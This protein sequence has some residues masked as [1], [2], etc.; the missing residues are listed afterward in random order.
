MYHN[1]NQIVHVQDPDKPLFLTDPEAILP[2]CSSGNRMI[3]EAISK[4]KEF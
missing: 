2:S 4:F 3:L 1:S